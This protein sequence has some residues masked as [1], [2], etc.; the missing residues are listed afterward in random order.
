[1]G[2]LVTCNYFQMLGANA[3]FGRTLLPADCSA[4]GRETVIILSYTAWQNKFGGDPHV[5]GKRLWLHG[6]PLEV[7]GVARRDFNGL[8]EVRREYWAPI[9]I[10]S[11]LEDGPDLFGPDH[12]NAIN[13]VVGRLKPG[14][15]VRQAKAA[16]TVWSQHMTADRADAE[17]ATGI[18]LQSRATAASLTREAVAL[19]TPIVVAFGIVLL[20][21][22]ANVANIMLARAVARQREI[23]V[24][25]SLGAG[26]RRLI[27]QLLTESVLLA[28][29]AGLVGFVI[30]QATFS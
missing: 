7:V 14:L 9:T 18:L 28:I 13:W 11:Q 6:H 15:H 27:R 12:P 19:G 22:C 23:G 4:P 1:M 16:L 17:K 29:P 10:A 5:M 21:A 8:G 3:A 24:R 30:S 2:E 25:L 26:R 20:L